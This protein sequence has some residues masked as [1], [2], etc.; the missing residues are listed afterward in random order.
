MRPGARGRSGNMLHYGSLIQNDIEKS[1]ILCNFLQRGFML[2]NEHFGAVLHVIEPH[3]LTRR[4][5]CA[6]RFLKIG[7]WVRVRIQVGLEHGHEP[8]RQR[9]R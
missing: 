8:H 4:F 6:S 3:P 7:V 2:I 1:V 9:G 5:V